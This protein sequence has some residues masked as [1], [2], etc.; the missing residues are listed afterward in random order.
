MARETVQLINSAGER[1][2]SVSVPWFM[3][4]EVDLDIVKRVHSLMF[5]GWHQPQ[6]R[7]PMAGKR[8]V[9]ESWGVDRGVSRVPR[10]PAGRAKFAPGTVKGRL[11]HPP[12][13]VK[14]IAKRVNAK[15]RL[16][17]V[18]SA[19]SASADPE[20]VRARGHALP[21]G[22]DLP[23]VFDDSVSSV[24]RTSEVRA[25]LEKL[26]LRAELERAS[27]F[28]RMSGAPASR[29]R[30]RKRRIG[31]LFVVERGRSLAR[32][33][34]NIPGVDVIAPTELSIRE[35]APNGTAGRLVLWSQSSLD[36]M[37][38]RLSKVGGKVRAAIP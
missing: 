10:T 32:A 22:L 24:S 21:E 2:S 5:S 26:G 36:V 20:L 16:L 15:E 27:R 6:G 11:G 31:P 34:R 8:T 28:R 9:A 29:G 37:D 3:R 38:K 12:S 7:D 4:A 33:A 18:L 23:I 1:V 17:A 14:V 35:L 25:L 19:T 30:I 13:A